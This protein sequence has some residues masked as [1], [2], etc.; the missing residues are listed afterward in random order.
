ML[1]RDILCRL[2]KRCADCGIFEK[3]KVIAAIDEEPRATMARIADMVLNLILLF[4]RSSDATKMFYLKSEHFYHYNGSDIA[5]NHRFSH[6][7]SNEYSLVEVRTRVVEV[8][9]RWEEEPQKV[10]RERKKHLC[11]HF[12][13]TRYR[14]AERGTTN[15]G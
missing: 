1:L 7:Q 10:T 13:H 6:D 4:A 12:A 8:G 2:L 5:I 9:G 3:L 14:A 15:A 11:S